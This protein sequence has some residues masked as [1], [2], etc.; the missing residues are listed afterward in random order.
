MTVTYQD[1][2]SVNDCEVDNNKSPLAVPHSEK[3]TTQDQESVNDCEVDNNKSPLAV[4]HSE[5]ATTQ[6]Q[7]SVNDCEVDNN[8]SPLAAPHSEKATTQDQ[9]SANKVDES[10]SLL[11]RAVRFQ[12][13]LNH[14][15]NIS[16]V[17]SEGDEEI[18]QTTELSNS[19]ETVRVAT[20]IDF[21]SHGSHDGSKKVEEQ[22]GQMKPSKHC[23]TELQYYCGSSLDQNCVLAQKPLNNLKDC[24]KCEECMIEYICPSCFFEHNVRKC[25][26]CILEAPRNNIDRK[27]SSPITIVEDDS[28]ENEEDDDAYVTDSERKVLR[29]KNI[30]KSLDKKLRISSI[31][32]TVNSKVINNSSFTFRKNSNHFKVVTDLTK[33]DDQ[34]DDPTRDKVMFQIGKAGQ[35][36]G[37]IQGYQSDIDCLRSDPKVPDESKQMTSSSMDTITIYHYDKLPLKNGKDIVYPLPTWF[38]QVISGLDPTYSAF[39]GGKTLKEIKELFTYQLLQFD[40][41]DRGHISTVGVTNLHSVMWLDFANRPIREL[42]LSTLYY[43][44]IIIIRVIYYYYIY[45]YS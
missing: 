21:S 22:I 11:I 18:I 27:N 36:N 43:L 37:V 34:N 2:E 23:A 29:Q 40:V 30:D 17:N 19:D 6:N 26:V 35:G 14:K 25:F 31:I 12:S 15:E 9:E 42:H 45:Y 10:S 24:P 5:K 20:Q 16:L 13:P 28:N 8:K 44:I 3:A 39:L 41:F 33:D 7:E 32:A 1:K 38:W 4:P